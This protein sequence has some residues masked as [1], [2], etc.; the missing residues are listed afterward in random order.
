[1]C[2]LQNGRGIWGRDLS[3]Q[4]APSG[5]DQQ[6]ALHTFA[7]SRGCGMPGKVRVERPLFA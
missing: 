1:M 7:Q 3:A 2:D 5:V 4:A 6:R